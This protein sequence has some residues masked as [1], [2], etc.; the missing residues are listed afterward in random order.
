MQSNDF[1][2]TFNSP[3]DFL[4]KMFLTLFFSGLFPVAPGSIGTLVALPLGFLISYH[5]APSTLLLS[6][7]LVAAI[8]IKIINH[9]EKQGL[10]H[11]SKQIVIDELAGVWISIAMIGHSVFELFLSYVLF[12]VFDIWKPSIVGRVD[13]NVKGGLG[14][15]GDDLLAGFFAG[16]LGIMIIEAMQKMESLA[17]ILN[18]SF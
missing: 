15:M 12:R 4:Q 8:A 11:D 17:P 1:F 5:I 9:Y 18:F 13:R 16:L 10:P 2:K 6:A 14:V 3:K 7:L